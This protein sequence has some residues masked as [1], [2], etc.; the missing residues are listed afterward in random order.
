[1]AV[2]KN[3]V[4]PRRSFIIFGTPVSWFL[5]EILSIGVFLAAMVHAGRRER[6][7]FH[8]LTL[9]VFVAFAGIFENIGVMAGV[10]QYDVNRVMMI[11]KVPLSILFVEAAVVYSALWL[12]Q[13]LR[14]PWW[15]AP[16]VVGLFSM[17]QDMTIDPSN[18]FDLHVLD[19]VTTGQWNWDWHYEGGFFGIPFY[20][21][22]GWFTMTLYYSFFINLIDW[23]LT[24]KGRR[25]AIADWTPLLALLPSLI[26]LVSPVNQFLLYLQPIVAPG[27]RT[28]ELV[29]MC[30]N[31][32]V[33]IALLVIYMKPNNALDVR[34]NLIVLLIPVV[35]HV[36]DI[37]LAYTVGIE[38]GRV[39]SVLVG[40]IHIAF[41]AWIVSKGRAAARSAVGH[42]A[43]VSPS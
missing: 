30:V 20:N 28:A 9:L 5:Y 40:A 33:G 22:S 16:F 32:A 39:P 6:G 37:A 7:G 1:L 4:H 24:R 27:N 12:T 10:Y 31:T 21:F 25:A 42:D 17:V 29:L 34:R 2:A 26:V 41:L 36:W 14:M 3:G 35:L 19:G 11:G 38:R 8:A 15:A 43:R 23:L 18:V 13:H